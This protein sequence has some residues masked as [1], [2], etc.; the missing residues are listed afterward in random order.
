MRNWFFKFAISILICVV[1][2]AL[3]IGIYSDFLKPVLHQNPLV[4]YF[5]AVLYALLI[6]LLYGYWLLYIP[7]VLLLNFIVL[8][9]GFRARPLK[10]KHR[11]FLYVSLGAFIGAV[12]AWPVL[13]LVKGLTWGVSWYEVGSFG[14]VGA[15][16]GVLCRFWIAHH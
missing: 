6:I 1:V 15:V 4:T 7:P 5:H 2:S 9:P 16:Y 8:H 14:M 3:L 13:L 11:T 10:D 12:Y